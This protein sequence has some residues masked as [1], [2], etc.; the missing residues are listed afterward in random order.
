MTYSI[1]VPFDGSEQALRAVEHA[2]KQHPE[3]SITVLCVINPAEAVYVTDEEG[4]PPFPEDWY[5][6]AQEQAELTLEDAQQIATKH[7]RT[8]ETAV[9]V[10]RPARSI[11]EYAE[12]HDVDHIIMGSHG[13]S[14]VSR[15]LLGSVAEGVMRRSP[16]PVTVVR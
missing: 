10:G 4:V 14:G 5:D 6:T 12:D 8:L 13:R 9:E 7:G 16:I 15:V 1:L 2:L 3:A 11:V